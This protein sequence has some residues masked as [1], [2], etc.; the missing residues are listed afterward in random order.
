MDKMKEFLVAERERLNAETIRQRQESLRE[1][2]ELSRTRAEAA[3]VV[4]E[5]GR[6]AATKEV[7]DTVAT[8]TALLERME[9][10]ETMRRTPRGQDRAE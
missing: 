3:R 5:T 4:A 10:V 8:L 7:S 9:A 6:V 2:D 1:A